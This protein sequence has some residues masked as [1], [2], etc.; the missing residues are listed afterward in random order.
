MPPPPDDVETFPCP[1]WQRQQR[2]D[3]ALDGRNS[4]FVQQ[5]SGWTVPQIQRLGGEG[6][7]DGGIVGKAFLMVGGIIRVVE[8]GKKKRRKRKRVGGPRF[9][10]VDEEGDGKLAQK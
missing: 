2:Y 7:D 3:N 1:W 10:W 6:N 4:W 9:A 8:G 5:A